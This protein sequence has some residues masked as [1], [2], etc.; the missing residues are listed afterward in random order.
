M[1]NPRRLTR[2]LTSFPVLVGLYTHGPLLAADV[3]FWPRFHGPKGDN[4][5]TETGLLREWP[6]QG[7]KLLWTAQPIG[8]GYAGVTIAEGRIYTAGD[9]GDFNVITA[10]DM[11]GRI[12]W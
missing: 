5:S 2:L 6:Q 7:P 4:I 9:M 3:P 8:H 10:M 11:D 12:R 1:L